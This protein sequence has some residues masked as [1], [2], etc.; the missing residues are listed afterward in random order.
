LPKNP[1]LGQASAGRLI[2]AQQA[3]TGDGN[4]YDDTHTLF[5][6]FQNIEENVP[7]LWVVGYFEF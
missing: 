2:P 4:K 6:T 5:Y 7:Q 1:S 3:A